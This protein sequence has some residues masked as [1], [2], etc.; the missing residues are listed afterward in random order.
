MRTKGMDA[1]FV[2][3]AKV[4]RERGFCVDTDTLQSDPHRTLRIVDF[5]EVRLHPPE[6]REP[7]DIAT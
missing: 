2:E 1:V 3:L 7:E 5:F 6:R 4:L